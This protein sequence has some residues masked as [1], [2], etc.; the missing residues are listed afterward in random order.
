MADY[1]V[2]ESWM[3]LAQID[4]ELEQVDN[5]GLSISHQSIPARDGHGIPVRIY[6]PTSP[7]SEGSPLI[8]FFHGGGF[9]L[10]NLD[11]EDL[12]CR[13]FAR[14]LGAVVV[15]VDYRLAPE[16]QFPAGPNDAW[17]AVQWAAANATTTLSATPTRGFIVGGTSAGG[18]LTAVTATLARDTGLTPPI[19]GL[20]L[21]IPAL[22]DTHNP[23]SHMAPHLRSFAQ[24]SDA[25]VL[26]R[27]SMEALVGPGG[28]EPDMQSRLFNIYSE[29]EPV[30]RAGL[31]PTYFQI[32]G[33]DPLRDEGLFLERELRETHGT[34]TRLKVWEG[35]PHGFWSVFTQLSKSKMWPGETVEGVKWL[36]EQGGGEVG[37]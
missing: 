30:S 12:V 13:K 18:N 28:Y 6:K 5:T 3:S 14:E 26:S 4:P 11:G 22:T 7:P 17:D 2:E 16:D 20:C 10:G 15:N 1:P 31:P 34:K 8:V 19:T 9:C 23:A 25:P 21:L 32:C 37:G 35:L 36:L 29:R 24:N 27:A 33:L